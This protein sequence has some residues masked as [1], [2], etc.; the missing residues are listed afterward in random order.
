MKLSLTFVAINRLLLS[1]RLALEESWRNQR[2]SRR[3][4]LGWQ[5]PEVL[6]LRPFPVSMARLSDSE[7][8]TFDYIKVIKG[9][10]NT[11]P[12]VASNLPTLGVGATPGKLG[13]L[14]VLSNS[15]ALIKPQRQGFLVRG[16][17]LLLPPPAA[18]GAAPSRGD[19]RASQLPAA[20]P[21]RGAGGRRS[22]SPVPPRLVPTHFPFW[23]RQSHGRARPSRQ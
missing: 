23:V 8:T 4:N 1:Y 17:G 18:R 9:R 19:P 3:Y 16:F 11:S 21:S 7:K 2:S 14:C 6:C 12:F 22:A 10:G 20:R 15:G 5:E 13:G